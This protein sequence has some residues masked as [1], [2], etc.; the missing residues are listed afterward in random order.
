MGLK[1]KTSVLMSQTKSPLGNIEDRLLRVPKS[2]RD[3]LN[4]SKGTFLKLKSKIGKDIILQ[5][6]HAYINDADV[7]PNSAYVSD[8][9]YVELDLR[10][11]TKLDPAED[12]LIGC[13]PEF[14]LVDADTLRNVSASHFF[15]HY[16]QVGSDL[17][18]AELRPRPAMT[19]ELLTYNIQQLLLRASD[20]LRERV[21]Y[22]KRL[23][24]MDAASHRD[25]ASAGFHIHFGLPKPL[26]AYSD[27]AYNIRVK[28]VNLLDYYIG[29]PSI[30]PEG[31]ED[32]YRR[33]YK[34]SN[35]GK[36][37]DFRSES[38]TL[39]YRVPGGHLLRHPLLTMGLISLCQLVMKDILT[40]IKAQ[41][42]GYQN[43]NILRKHSELRDLYPNL[44]DPA[45]VYSAVTD[46]KCQPALTHATKIFA[47]LVNMIGFEGNRNHITKYFQYVL[48]YYQQGNKFSSN[49]DQNWR[50]F[51]NE[52]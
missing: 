50:S 44:P 41:T 23:I 47:D 7:D 42:N 10:Q 13:D 20:H 52:G 25:G 40:R 15:P 28:I 6:T 46:E 37:G 31:D 39:E 35:Y 22:R 17:G 18:L 45:N 29:I 1:I 8:D 30:L 27:E 3:Q 4:I 2:L 19:A 43:L 5:V 33:S 49:I 38:V 24:Y 16:G 34:Y 11:V 36:P 51:R 9:V 21:L 48:N 12:I 32:F 14:F 26:L